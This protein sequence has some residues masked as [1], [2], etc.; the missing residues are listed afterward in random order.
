VVSGITSGLVLVTGATG[1]GKTC[2]VVGWL[3]QERERP[4][5][6]MGV[7]DLAV[8]HTAAPPVAEWVEERISPEDETLRLPYFRFPTDSVLVLDEAQRVYPPRAV[9]S[10]VP[11]HVGALS[12]RRHTGLD[13]VLITQHPSLIDAA[14][15]KLVTHHYHVHSTPY[16]AY[17][18]YWVGCGEP[19]NKA[20]R[21]IAERKRYKPEAKHFA[22]YKS[23]EAHTRVRRRVPKA[24]IFGGVL[25]VAA[26]VFGG[27][28]Y[29]RMTA[30]RS[31]VAEEAIGSPDRA[32]GGIKRE[33]SS[34]QAEVLGYLEARRPAVPGLVHT[35]PAYADVAKVVAV[36]YP[37]GCVSTSSRCVCYDQ[38][39][40][41]YQTTEAV[42]RQ[43]MVR[44]PFLDFLADAKSAGEGERLRPVGERTAEPAGRAVPVHVLGGASRPL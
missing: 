7:P 30:D 13:V 18:L 34:G 6:V 3:A 9:G 26:V 15:R 12:T 24:A 1:S 40:G 11:E 42:C 5:Y 20:S 19:S 41:V 23:A 25:V 4:L 37:T 21:D 8:P 10:K 17:L 29:Q 43:W 35:A 39:G 31:V 2:L 14:V 44:A 32:G 33:V 38:R 16:G 36:P 28:S 22:L 27:L